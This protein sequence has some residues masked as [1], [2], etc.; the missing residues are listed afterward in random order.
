MGE[1]SARPGQLVGVAQVL[2]GKPARAFDVAPVTEP[3]ERR[4]GI[5][6][7]ERCERGEVCEQRVDRRPTTDVGQRRSRSGPDPLIPVGQSSRKKVNIVGL[8]APP[9][10]SNHGDVHRA[11]RVAE[12]PAQRRR[13]T[14]IVDVSE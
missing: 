8:P 12:S 11:C 2:N 5:A 13:C 7:L 4:L 9:Q 14:S 10:T 1:Q 6:S 3:G